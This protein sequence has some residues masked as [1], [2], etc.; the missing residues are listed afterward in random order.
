MEETDR[1]AIGGKRFAEELMVF[2]GH[3]LEQRAL[4]RSVQA[5]YADFCSGQERQPDILQNGRVRG[6]DLPQTFHGVDVLHSGDQRR[7]IRDRRPIRLS[8]K[9]ADYTELALTC[10]R[11]G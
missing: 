1:N 3:D 2:P 4:A 7:G 8:P 6:I 10:A 11:M 9:S 5:E